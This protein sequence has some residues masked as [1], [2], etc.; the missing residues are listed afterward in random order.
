[1]LRFF[2]LLTLVAFGSSSLL[3]E[4]LCYGSKYSLPPEFTPP[5]YNKTIT[6]SPKVGDPKTVVNKGLSLDPRFQVSQDG[7]EM[8]DLTEQD[9]EAILST[10]ASV[11]SV[12][13]II[14]NCGSILRK[15][16]GSSVVWNIPGGAEYLEFS[17]F[18]GSDVPAQ[19]TILWNRTDSSYSRGNVSGS[20]YKIKDLTQQDSGY[21]RFRGSQ[22]QLLNWE[23]IQV[24]EHVKNHTYS[25]GNYIVINFP[26]EITP[27]Q[28][29]F[30]QKGADT[31]TVLENGGRVDITDRYLAIEES[32]YEDAGTYDFVDDKGNLILRAVIGI[33]EEDDPPAHWFLYL[34]VSVFFVAFAVL[35]G[36]FCWKR[37]KNKRRAAAETEAV[38]PAMNYLRVTK[39]N[40]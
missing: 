38:P 1:M 18:T 16:Y 4:E 5:V 40:E 28:V 9:N 32:T 20:D 6:Y 14:K 34:A 29:R 7:I 15:L 17:K 12:K 30:T 8:K 2:L 39:N 19:P 27:S 25:K 35:G 26:G 13:L 21:Y 36:I 22:H 31:Y 33:K 23:Q 10:E 24:Q 11:N 3:T 37:Y